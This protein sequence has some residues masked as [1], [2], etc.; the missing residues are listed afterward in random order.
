M[1]RVENRAHHVIRY[2]QTSTTLCGLHNMSHWVFWPAVMAAWRVDVAG[3]AS[4]FAAGAFSFTRVL[5]MPVV[6][7]K[8]E[9]AIYREVFRA[10]ISVR[11]RKED[12]SKKRTFS[13]MGDISF[14]RIF[15]RSGSPMNKPIVSSSRRMKTNGSQMLQYLILGR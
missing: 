1:V 5:N 10:A 9:P 3:C 14:R 13:P 4:P 7:L 6:S 15:P 12:T 2:R 11:E 8:N